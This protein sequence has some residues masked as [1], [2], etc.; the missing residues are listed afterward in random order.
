MTTSPGGVAVAALAGC[1]GDGLSRHRITGMV[2]FEGKPVEFGAIFFESIESVGKVAPTVYLPIRGGKLDTGDKGYKG[3]SVFATQAHLI[4]CVR[5][6]RPSES[7]GRD[8]LK[9]VALVEACYRSVETGNRV[10]PEV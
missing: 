5:S 9:T 2:T 10:R 3:D 1:R 6:G 8:Y 7:D 4:E